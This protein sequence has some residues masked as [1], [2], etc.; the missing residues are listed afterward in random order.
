[1]ISCLALMTLVALLLAVWATRGMN[2]LRGDTFEYVYFDPSRT[3]GYP[4][5]LWLMRLLTGQIASAVPMQ[6]T[7]LAISLLL[8]GW[9]FHNLVRV[10]AISF[11]FQAALLGQPEIWK[12]SAFLMTEGLSAALI[13]AWCAQLLRSIKRP[14]LRAPVGLIAISAVATMVRPSLVALFFGTAIFAFVNLPRRN[15]E[16]SL[17]LIAFGAVLAWGCTP[18]AQLVVHGS[19]NTTSPFSRG[20]LQH[21]LFCDPHIVPIHGDAALV[22]REAAPVRDYIGTAPPGVQEQLRRAYSTA[23]RFG[24]IIPVLGERHHRD[25]RSEVDPYLWTIASD[26]V[27]ANPGCYAESVMGAYFRMALFDV[28]R[29]SEADRRAREFIAAH[30]PIQLPQYPVLARDN[31]QIRTIAA[32]A[33]NQPSGLNPPRQ[34]LRFDDKAPR[35]WLAPVQLLYGAAALIGLV[36]LAFALR[37]RKR[38]GQDAPVLAVMATMGAAFHALLAITS[39]VE[40][41]LSRYVIPLWPVVCTLDAIAIL[42]VIGSCRKADAAAAF[43]FRSELPGPIAVAGQMADDAGRMR[44]PTAAEMR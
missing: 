4:A 34:E 6:M 40:L 1:M 10:P 35:L 33:R 23:L 5:F 41:G 13:A 9:S 14:T 16:R 12:S 28:N 30:P 8:L 36:S 37:E 42:M 43:P 25:A 3:M 32:E 29:S 39:I 24:L 27:K 11:A 38:L 18:V 20:V 19:P 2:P 7:L 26:R 21:T 15:R 31:L 22:E 44:F 17:L